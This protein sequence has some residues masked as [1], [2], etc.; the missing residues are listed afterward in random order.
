M[1]PVPRDDAFSRES[2]YFYGQYYA[3]Q[4]MWHAGGDHWKKWYPAI[5]D[6]LI[7]RQREDGSWT[8]SI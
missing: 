6:A 8:D 7:A 2:H 1:V 4:A 5:H 3:A